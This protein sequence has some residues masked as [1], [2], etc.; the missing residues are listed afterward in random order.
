MEAVDLD[1]RFLDDL[2]RNIVV[3]RGDI[4]DL[5]LTGPLFD[6]IHA[7]FVLIHNSKVGELLD[8]LLQHLAPGG[9]LALEEPDFGSAHAFVA[10]AA[11]RAA[12]DA[13]TGAIEA[14]F[15]ERKQ[16][17]DFGKELP[18]LLR[19]RGL[20]MIRI[21]S[22]CPVAKGGSPIARMMAMSTSQLGAKYLATGHVT[23]EQLDR[24]ASFSNDPS[25][26]AV[27]HATVRVL[28]K[29]PEAT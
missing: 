27:Y 3:T 23:R 18:R 4:R 1:I 6:L 19:E 20:E 26:W 7:R 28:A 14:V 21:Q 11:D 9:H 8:A 22:D 10:S 13:V 16:R 5:E 15:E 17:H 24:Y 2:S 12:F 25:T 29:K